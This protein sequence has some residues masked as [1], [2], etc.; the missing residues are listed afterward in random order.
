[1]CAGVELQMGMRT[2]I[3]LRSSGTAK[4]CSAKSCSARTGASQIAPDKLCPRTC[5]A[6]R[7]S[8]GQGNDA[9]ELTVIALLNEEMLHRGSTISWDGTKR[10]SRLFF[11]P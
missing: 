3:V 4:S 2:V 10:P 9:N 1:M 8:F 7:F 11:V 5:S 6:D